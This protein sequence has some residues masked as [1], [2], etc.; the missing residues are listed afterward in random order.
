MGSFLIS[1]VRP[2]SVGFLSVVGQNQKCNLNPYT[3]RSLGD[4][5]EGMLKRDIQFSEEGKK[6]KKILDV[7]E[8]DGTTKIKTFKA[9]VCHIL[10]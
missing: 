4:V 1:S 10:S 7:P 3:L 9:D 6:N 5:S 8:C 2:I